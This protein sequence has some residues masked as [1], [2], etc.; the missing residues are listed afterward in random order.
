M[1][2]AGMRLHDLR[3]FA[4]TRLLAAGIPVRTVRGRLGHSNASTTLSVYAHF[5]EES[6]RDA[7]HAIGELLKRSAEPTARDD[8]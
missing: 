6:D 1:G 4:A 2:L 5:L 8:R 3:H 7:A